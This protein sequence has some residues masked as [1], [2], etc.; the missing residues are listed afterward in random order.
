[1]TSNFIAEII[2]NMVIF[3]SSVTRITPPSIWLEGDYHISNL[4]SSR[5]RENDLTMPLWKHTHIINKDAALVLFHN[6]SL[7]TE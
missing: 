4:Q 2:K 1:M 3:H 7:K 5:D 6:V